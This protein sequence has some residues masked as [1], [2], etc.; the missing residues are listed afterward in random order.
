MT[1]GMS[2]GMK[3]GVKKYRLTKITVKTRESVWLA[4]QAANESDA[5]AC[6]LCHSPMPAFVPPAPESFSRRAAEPEAGG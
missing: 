1:N 6:P 4:K 2:N 3:N 5:S